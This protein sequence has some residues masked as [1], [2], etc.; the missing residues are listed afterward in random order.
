MIDKTKL[1]YL[2]RLG[3]NIQAMATQAKKVVIV[4][5]RVIDDVA[6]NYPDFEK[7]TIADY[8]TKFGKD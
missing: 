6:K 2:V 5:E 4:E 1:Y 8:E 7:I 3:T